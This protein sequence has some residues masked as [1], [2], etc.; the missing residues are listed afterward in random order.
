[1]MS[2][3]PVAGLAV[4]TEAIFASDQTKVLLLHLASSP[5]ALLP[6]KSAVALICAFVQINIRFKCD[7]LAVAT[8]VVSSFHLFAH[9]Q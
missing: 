9:F 3:T 1:M 8:A 6:A 5:H 7:G 2:F 4:I